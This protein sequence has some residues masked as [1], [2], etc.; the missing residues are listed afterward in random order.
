MYQVLKSAREVNCSTLNDTN[1]D[2][3]E[4]CYLQSY[5]GTS[6]CKKCK[7]RSQT[8]CND[9]RC[10]RPNYCAYKTDT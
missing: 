4:Q 3:N 2:N 1:C 9:N 7:L 10:Y 5:I 8:E 6:V